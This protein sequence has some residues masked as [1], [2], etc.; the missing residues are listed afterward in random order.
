MFAC[1]SVFVWRGEGKRE[2]R[3]VVGVL[4]CAVLCE[5]FEWPGNAQTSGTGGRLYFGIVMASSSNQLRGHH[6]R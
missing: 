4:C 3:G 2:R 1:V 6:D 5:D